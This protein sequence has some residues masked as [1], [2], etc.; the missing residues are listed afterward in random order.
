MRI[1]TYAEFR[2]AVTLSEQRLLTLRRRGLI[3]LAFG[4]AE[5]W[6]G[7]VYFE[8]DGVGMVLAEEIAKVF[9]RKRAAQ[10][11]RCW[12]EVWL[13]AVAHAEHPRGNE[14]PI[15]FDVLEFDREGGGRPFSTL[16][17]GAPPTPTTS[18]QT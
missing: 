11:V 4:R 2:S 14:G 7:S 13:E 17:G 5:A 8:I 16:P 6:K 9:D 10:I 15:F 18:S 1:I 3:S 12:C